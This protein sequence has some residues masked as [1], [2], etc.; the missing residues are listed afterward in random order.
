MEEQL[1]EQEDNVRK[2]LVQ[3]VINEAQEKG[4]PLSP[5]ILKFMQHFKREYCC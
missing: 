2:A 5:A 4:N 1:I 3:D